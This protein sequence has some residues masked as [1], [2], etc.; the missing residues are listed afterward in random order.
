MK[1]RYAYS[2]ETCK[3]IKVICMFYYFE[4]GQWIFE[5]SLTDT[6]WKMYDY[7]TCYSLG[8]TLVRLALR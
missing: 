7:K 4:I 1:I 2:F 8:S 3:T 5:Q 6:A